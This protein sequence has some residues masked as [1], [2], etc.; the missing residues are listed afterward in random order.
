MNGSGDVGRVDGVDEDAV[1]GVERRVAGL[2]HERD[3]TLGGVVGRYVEVTDE[4]VDGGNV[5]DA[6]AA[7]LTQKRDGMLGA[8]EDA[9]DVHR[10]D[11]V[12]LRLGQLVRRLI[13]AADARVV[14]EDIE[15]AEAACDLW[16]ALAH[17][18]L[19]GHVE[20]EAGGLAARAA[21]SSATA[22]VPGRSTSV[23]ATV[24]PSSASSRQVGALAM[25]PPPPVTT[26]TFPRRDAP[27]STPARERSVRAGV[28]WPPRGVYPCGRPRSPRGSGVDGC[29]ERPGLLW[30]GH[31]LWNKRPS[32]LRP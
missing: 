13:D 12:P 19:D 11:R 21:I 5:D 16:Q 25:P 27:Q 28:S 9:L 4:P 17:L 15:A 26:A 18:L 2:G 14:H 10:E 3:R 6:A 8:E 24:A 20:G 29:D 7:G 30:K 31:H 23:T 22:R 32:A 1:R